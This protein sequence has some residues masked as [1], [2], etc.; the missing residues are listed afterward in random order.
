MALGTMRWG[1]GT[2]GVGLVMIGIGALTLAAHASWRVPSVSGVEHTAS[3]RQAVV[4]LE[5]GPH[6]SSGTRVGSTAA[7]VSFVIPDGWHAA[8]PPGSETVYLESPSQ[9]GLGLIAV[10]RHITPQDLEDHLNEP[11][12]IDEGY[13]LHPARSAQRSGDRITVAYQSGGNT[14]RA[15]ALFG[16]SQNGVLYL[17]TGPKDR[18]DY[19]GD[20]VQQL[21]EST[22]FTNTGT[23]S[24]RSKD[25]R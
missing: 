13:V 9:P 21:A 11:Q 17:L 24:G 7:G 3:Q 22:R 19:Y 14:G 2:I 5:S 10:F 4:E 12:V 15:L 16:P 23:G 25:P 20:I 18:S 1:L 8:I 6:Y